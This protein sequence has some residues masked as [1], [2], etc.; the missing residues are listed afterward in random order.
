MITMILIFDLFVGSYLISGNIECSEAESIIQYVEGVF[1]NGPKPICQ[2]LFPSQHLTNRVVKLE[3]G[4]SYVYPIKGLNP[5][6]ENS[7]LIHYIQ[8]STHVNHSGN[9]ALC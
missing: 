1:F 2:P 6:N 3:R 4:M 5:S 8:V 9:T 7:A